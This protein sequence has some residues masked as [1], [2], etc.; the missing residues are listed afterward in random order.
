LDLEVIWQPAVVAAVVSAI[1]GPLIFFFLKRWDEKNRRNFE[2]RYSEY[3]H[4]LKALEDIASASQSDFERFMRETY[5]DCLKDI[6]ATEGRSDEPLLRL[7]EEVNELTARVRELFSQ[8]T[9]E[10]NGL[11]LVCSDEL[12][13]MVNEFVEIQRSL[14]NDSCAVLSRLDQVDPNDPSAMLSGDMRQQGERSQELFEQIVR[15]MRKEL[16][17][18]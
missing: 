8:A 2:I 9:Q 1:V 4:Y 7:N 12:L 10:L 6:L 16:G 11:R 5:A 13:S 3:K 17:I 18:K 14:L 15:Q